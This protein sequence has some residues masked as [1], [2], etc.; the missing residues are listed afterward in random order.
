MKALAEHVVESRGSPVRSFV[1]LVSLGNENAVAVGTPLTVSVK[2]KESA[3]FS[4]HSLGLTAGTTA[5]CQ[6]VR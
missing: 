1:P 3:W 2:W 5:S 6:S 4:L